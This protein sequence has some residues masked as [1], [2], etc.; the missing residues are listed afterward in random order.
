MTKPILRLGLAAALVLGL[1]GNATALGPVTPAEV[2]GFAPTFTP[3][4]M[5]GRTCSSGGR[6]IP[7][8]PEVCYQRGLEYCGSS[9]D[10]AP[11]PPAVVVPGLGLR[12]EGGGGRGYRE[13]PR[14]RGD[15]CRTITVE[16]DD[17]TVRRM[18]RCD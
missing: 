18:R 11:N 2:F 5:C 10:P 1:A 6:Y 7:G 13:E 9:R 12:I 14:P 4:A 16:R 15:G 3:A 17:G 8:P